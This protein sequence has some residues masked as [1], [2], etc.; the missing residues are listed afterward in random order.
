[1]HC[2][3]HVGLEPMPRAGPEDDPHDGEPARERAH[4]DNSFPV[5]LSVLIPN[6]PSVLLPLPPGSSSS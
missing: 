2:E 3:A 6:S 4:A 1:M 5:P